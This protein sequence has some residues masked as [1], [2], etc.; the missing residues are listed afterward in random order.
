MCV[1]LRHGGRT[2]RQAAGVCERR[3]APRRWPPVCNYGAQAHENQDPMTTRQKT[4]GVVIGAIIWSASGL[5]ADKILDAPTKVLAWQSPPRAADPTPVRVTV[6]EA[7]R[8]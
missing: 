5:V 6:A 8:L 3:I 7:P 1:R 2:R 4:L